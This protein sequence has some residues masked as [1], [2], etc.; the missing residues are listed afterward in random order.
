MRCIEIKPC[1]CTKII[2][3]VLPRHTKPTWGS[4]RSYQSNTQPGSRTLG[5]SLL[6]EILVSTSQ[7]RQVENDGHPGVRFCRLRWKED[8][9]MHTAPKHLALV[10]VPTNIAIKALRKSNIHVDSESRSIIQCIDIRMW[11]PYDYLHSNEQNSGDVTSP[12]CSLPAPPFL[13]GGQISAGI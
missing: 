3:I 7:P 10:L 1:S 5:S 12:C 13:F 6:N 8:R 2:R 4:V 9:K 11:Y